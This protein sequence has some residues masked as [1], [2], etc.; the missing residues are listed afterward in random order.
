[1]TGEESGNRTNLANQ[2]MSLS[3]SQ[4]AWV[5]G[6][7]NQ[8]QLPSHYERDPT[9]DFVSDE[10][11]E[12]VGD[13]LRIHHAFSRQALSKDRFE[14]ALERALRL[15]GIDA[16]LADSRTNRGHDMTVNG[17]R[18]SLKT[19]ADASI[20]RDQIHV[21]KWMEL[22]RGEWRL[23]LLRDLFIEHMTGYD[24]I[25][26]FRRLDHGPAR[27]EYELVEIPKPLM[28]E[29]QGAVLEVQEASRQNPK[30]G[31]GYIRD[32]VGVL[33]FSM[34]FDGG[35]ERKLQIRGLQKSLCITHAN[36]AFDS[37]DLS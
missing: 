26:T 23:D 27:Y 17:S 6:V 22:G 15:C 5:Q 8:F 36:W 10:V 4:Q 30:P 14:Y 9:S 2:L 34:Y 28:L 18:V 12:R 19:Q 1:M 25:F 24:R 31:Y 13:A 32:D 21:S 3:G 20:R 16:K 33:K 11:L 7:I 35:S 29:A 37:A